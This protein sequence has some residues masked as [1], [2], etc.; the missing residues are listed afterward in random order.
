MSGTCLL[1]S[2]LPWCCTS[3]HNPSAVRPQQRMMATTVDHGRA[4]TES[5]RV[6]ERPSS[7]PGPSWFAAIDRYLLHE[8]PGAGDVAV[9]AHHLLRRLVLVLVS[10]AGRDREPY[11]RARCLALAALIQQF[12]RLSTFTARSGTLRRGDL[13][14]S[15]CVSASL[16]RYSDSATSPASHRA[17]EKQSN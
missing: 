17:T 1:P 11:A 10:R 16:R 9:A 14:D 6:R 12:C 7:P 5:P 3:V 2:A 4:T 15:L 13:L 8:I